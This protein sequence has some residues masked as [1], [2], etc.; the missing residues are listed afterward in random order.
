MRVK[1]T[2]PDGRQEVFNTSG[3]NMSLG[4]AAVLF[5]CLCGQSRFV[6][7]G[8][9]WTCENCS[10]HFEFDEDEDELT[11]YLHSRDVPLT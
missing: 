2:N 7:G 4:L 10:R 6:D 5:K 8:E 3:E 1:L 9:T 11:G